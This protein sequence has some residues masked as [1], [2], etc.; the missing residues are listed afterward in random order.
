M[1]VTEMEEFLKKG[2]DMHPMGRLGTIEEVRSIYNCKNS[3]E[4][5][6]NSF[7]L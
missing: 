3:F 4:L 2:C 5:L 6:Q 1:N 7:F